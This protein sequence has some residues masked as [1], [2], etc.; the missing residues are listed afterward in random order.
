MLV[1]ILLTIIIIILLLFLII[2]S[3]LRIEI[4]NY[5]RSNLY[6]NSHKLNNNIKNKLN[7]NTKYKIK[8]S[9]NVFD[10][11]KIL[12]LNLNKEKLKRMTLK[13]HLDK[14]DIKKLEKEIGI[15]DIKEI[16]QIE[17]KISYMNLNIKVGIDDVLLTTYVVPIICTAISASLPFVVEK[18]NYEKIKYLV[19]PIYN[20]GNK[21]DIK[22][23]MGIKLRLFKLFNVL[24][25]IYKNKKIND[26]KEK[27]LKKEKTIKCNV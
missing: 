12:Q 3:T 18:R 24:Y 21:Y 16:M 23:S 19:K 5:E 25:K 15:I 7:Y 13:M 6:Y 26:S 4:R 17:P 1:L 2:F 9:L 11:L 27:I 14:I 10:K 20:K 22:L 8:V